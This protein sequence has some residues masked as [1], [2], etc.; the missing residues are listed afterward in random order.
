MGF[1]FRGLREYFLNL[2][3]TEKGAENE[4]VNHR[5]FVFGSPQ[6]TFQNV[7]RVTQSLCRL[8][9]LNQSKA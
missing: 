3:L 9:R 2:M 1:Y 5:T 6:Q 4:T 7:A 8:E